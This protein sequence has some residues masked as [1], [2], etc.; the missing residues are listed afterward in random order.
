MRMLTM[1]LTLGISIYTTTGI[2]T[3]IDKESDIVTVSDFNG[4]QFEFYE[5]EDWLPG[6]IASMVMYDNG[7]PEVEDD[8]ILDVTYVGYDLEIYELEVMEYVDS[9]LTVE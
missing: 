8:I 9:R 6:D 3:D 5:V 4:H 2:V 7:T 1:L